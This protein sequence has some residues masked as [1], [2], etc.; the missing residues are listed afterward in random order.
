VLHLLLLLQEG[1]WIDRVEVGAQIRGRIE[2]RDPRSYAAVARDHL[3]YLSRVRTHVKVE[4]SPDLEIFLQGQDDRQ[5]DH[6][7]PAATKDD[8]L[9]VKQ[10]WFE[11]RNIDGLPLSA[12]V[13]RQLLSYGDQRLVSPL[14]WSNAGRAWDAAR[15]R[16]SG[17]HWSVDGFASMFTDQNETLEDH[18]F[19]AIY[20]T[21]E[22]V[23]GHTFD[24]YALGRFLGR[25]LATRDELGNVG[26]VSEGTFGF[27]VKGKEEPFD[28]A[29]EGAYQ[30]GDWV[31]TPIRAWGFAAT[32]GF[33]AGDWRFAAEYTAASGDAD[34]ADGRRN[35][36]TAPYPFGHYYQGFA[37]VF[38][39]RNGHDAAGH[40]RWK[41]C[42][43]ATIEL[44]IHTFWLDERRD[45]WYNAAQAVIRRDLTGASDPLVGHEIDVHIRIAV[46]KSIALW[47]GYSRF[48]AGPFVGDTGPAPDMDWLFFQVTVELS[49]AASRGGGS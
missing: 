41:P 15:I 19:C 37:D 43:E 11:F 36:F 34:P 29:A 3:L 1:P 46:S 14:D 33:T 35:T 30:T 20:A 47:T 6:D 16:Y 32:V 7:G 42:K 24:I 9:D 38:S 31:R 12:K 40:L 18:L 48:I 4:F 49:S 13:G 26:S 2:A 5:F 44:S 45:A 8:N 27:R 10:A 17:Q 25:A 39:W 28:Y 22:K 23:Q 21:C